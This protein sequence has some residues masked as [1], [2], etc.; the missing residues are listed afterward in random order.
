MNYDT[1]VI[2]VDMDR[3]EMMG[4]SLGVAAGILAKGHVVALPTETVYGL[5]ANALDPD[6][7]EKIFM[8]KGRPS[9]NPLIVHIGKVQEM[10]SLVRHT[11]VA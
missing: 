1:Q 9:D 4:E 11:P 7:V 5:G 2:D 3:D 10:E 6:A 8:A